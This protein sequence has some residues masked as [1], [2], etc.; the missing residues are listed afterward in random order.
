MGELGGELT[1]LTH[2]R[3][4]K[5]ERRMAISELMKQTDDG[6]TKRRFDVNELSSARFSK[7]SAIKWRHFELLKRKPAWNA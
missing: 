5:A 4:L 7:I 2:V 1:E 3:D 6:S